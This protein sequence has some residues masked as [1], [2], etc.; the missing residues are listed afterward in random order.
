MIHRYP[1]DGR[2]SGCIPLTRADDVLGKRSADGSCARAPAPATAARFRETRCTRPHQDG[3]DFRQGQ[4]CHQELIAE[5]GLRLGEPWN[6]TG[7]AQDCRHTGRW[8]SP[9]TVKPLDLTAE[10]GSPAN[11]TALR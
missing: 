10:V 1:H 9:V 7:P 5:L 11:A 8:D 4:C 2:Q 6:L 3:C